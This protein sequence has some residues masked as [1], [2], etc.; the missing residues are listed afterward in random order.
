MS[1]TVIGEGKFLIWD[2]WYVML[3][4]IH[5]P[6]EYVVTLISIICAV[7]GSIIKITASLNISHGILELWVTFQ[8]SNFCSNAAYCCKT[9]SALKQIIHVVNIT[10]IMTPVNYRN[11]FLTDYSDYSTFFASTRIFFIFR[12]LNLFNYLFVKGEDRK[13]NKDFSTRKKKHN[14][15]AKIWPS[16][17]LILRQ[18]PILYADFSQ[19]SVTFRNKISPCIKIFPF[20]RCEGTVET[21]ALWSMIYCSTQL[22]K[23]HS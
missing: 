18:N 1:Y 23:V 2:Y 11:I 19:I 8:C 9:F 6:D 13:R 12:G 20:Q 22:L 14:P 3:A 21:T 16:H 10:D 4:H 17:K 15:D 7:F 5:D